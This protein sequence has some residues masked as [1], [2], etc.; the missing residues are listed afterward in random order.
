MQKGRKILVEA[1]KI[2][3]VPAEK[4]AIDRTVEF[5]EYFH[6]VNQ[7]LNLSAHKNREAILVNLVIDSLTLLT[8][9][10]FAKSQLDKAIDVG[11]GGGIPGIPLAIFRPETHFVLLESKNKKYLFLEE[12]I[13]K[14]NLSNVSVICARAEDVAR[15][16]SLRENFD[17]VL[18][19][20]LA[21][22]NVALEITIPFLKTGKSAFFYKGPRYFQELKDAEGAL[23]ILGCKARK[24]WEIDVP[25]TDRKSYLIEIEKC[26][27]TPSHLPR[28]AGLPQKKPLS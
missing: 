22:L 4:E 27:P 14:L 13:A 1:L 17:T 28:K 9:E 23:K 18:S 10:S 21:P 19:K 2:L 15:E 5:V 25:W 8:V 20:A 6:L 7:N 24:I 12:V 16:K 3:K 26:M 11:S